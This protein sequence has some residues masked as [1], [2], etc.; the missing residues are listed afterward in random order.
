[1]IAITEK[2][3]TQLSRMIEKSFG[4][5]LKSE[6]KSLV[7]SRL[8]NILQEKGFKSYSQY[9]QYLINDKTGAAKV[10]LVNRI[11]T[12]HTFFLREKDHFDFLYNHVLPHFAENKR[13]EPIKIWSAGCS[14]GE[15]PYTL[16]MVIRDFVN[17]NKVNLNSKILATDISEKVLS[18]AIAG[19]YQGESVANLP[20]M[21]KL[22]YFTKMDKDTFKVNDDIKA[23]ITFNKFNLM[24]E[25]PFRSKFH[26]IFCRNVMIYFNSDTRA[27]LLKKFYDALVDGGYLF[28]GKSES[29]LKNEAG[30]KYVIPSIYRKI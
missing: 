25:F 21:W 27:R 28:I 15:E 8:Q 3:F 4:I 22:S 5:Y 16:A 29:I 26:V 14:S 12:N 23:S 30:F 24:D 6:K 2:E 7:M 17:N 13:H 19:V 10:E 1:M 11:T 18:K 9:Y 20:A